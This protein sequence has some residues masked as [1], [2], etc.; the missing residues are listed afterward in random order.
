MGLEMNYTEDFEQLWLIYPKRSPNNNK[1]DAYKQ[2]AARLK[3][4]HS[5]GDIMAGTKR[6]GKCMEM[7]GNI[8]TPFVMCG[9]TFLG[10]SEHF[11]E[12]WEPPKPEIKETTE[13]KGI[14]LNMPARIGESMDQWERRIAQAR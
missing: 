14:R 3:Q 4:G 12:E 2:Y 1:R 9:K 11:M 5:H 6:Y 10:A 7:M 8:G 13:Q